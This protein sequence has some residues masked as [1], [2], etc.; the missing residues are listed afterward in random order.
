M[1]ASCPDTAWE[2]LS[3]TYRFAA[4]DQIRARPAHG[5]LDHIGDKGGQDKGDEKTEDCNMCLVCAGPK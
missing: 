3:K 1:L 2:D 5:V 4:R